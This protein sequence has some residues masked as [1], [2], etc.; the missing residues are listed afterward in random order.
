MSPSLPETHGFPRLA[1]GVPVDEFL[2][3]EK[4]ERVVALS[5]LNQ[6]FALG[7][8]N[9]VV[10]RVTPDYPLNRDEFEVITLKEGDSVVAAKTSR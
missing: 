2:K 8:K 10:K 6:V 5:P 4:P 7:T 3:L 9:G 1:N